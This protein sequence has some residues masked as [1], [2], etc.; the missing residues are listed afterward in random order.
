VE[1]L[2][3]FVSFSE[4]MNFNGYI[5]RWQKFSKCLRRAPVP[6]TSGKSTS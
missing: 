3:N 1:I 5:F 6:P 4:Y 2:Q